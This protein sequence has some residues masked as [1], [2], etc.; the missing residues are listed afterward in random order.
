MAFPHAVDLHLSSPARLSSYRHTSVV[1][2]QG[3]CE[4]LRPSTVRWMRWRS[5]PER[6]LGGNASS[7]EGDR[8]SRSRFKVRTQEEHVASQNMTPPPLQFPRAMA[9]SVTPARVW[10]LCFSSIL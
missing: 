6:P 7:Q 3:T 9:S 1:A 4:T 2:S 5:I 8:W 10:I